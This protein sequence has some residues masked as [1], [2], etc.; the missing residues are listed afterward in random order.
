MNHEQRSDL[1]KRIAFV[2]PSI[3][4]LFDEINQTL[5][6]SDADIIKTAM[7]IKSWQTTGH[8]DQL[9]R[10][11]RELKELESNTLSKDGLDL[12]NNGIKV[13]R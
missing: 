6:L 11:I 13:F 12:W 2:L 10:W 9:N 5:V 7:L 1:C 4:G 3:A 8:T